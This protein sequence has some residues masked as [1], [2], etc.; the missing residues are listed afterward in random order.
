MVIR[1]GTR[2]VPV[3]VRTGTERVV[4]RVIV[5]RTGIYLP[6]F[7]GEACD[8]A[9]AAAVLE[10]GEVRRLRRTLL[11]ALAALEPVRR[12]DMTSTSWGC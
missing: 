10:A 5:R 2:R 3:V 6:R 7:L 4:E 11:A 8:R 1:T 9:E 12:W